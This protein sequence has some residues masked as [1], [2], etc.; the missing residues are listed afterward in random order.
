MRSSVATASAGCCAS[1]CAWPSARNNG[2][3]GPHSV[4]ARA[5]CARPV[6]SAVLRTPAARER[7]RLLA[8]LA[9]RQD[10]Q[11]ETQQ[12]HGLRTSP[13]ATAAAAA[14]PCRRRRSGRSSGSQI[15]LRTAEARAVERVDQIDAELEAA[16]AARGEALH[17]ADVLGVRTPARATSRT[18]G[19]VPGR[20]G[21]PCADKRLRRK[22][23]RV[24]VR[25]AAHD[26]EVRPVED[27]RVHALDD[28]G[29]EREAGVP[30]LLMRLSETL[31]VPPLR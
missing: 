15:G 23:R 10:R 21:T 19:A 17:Q 28:V 9:R 26:I 8:V 14:R 30:G 22:R 1:S 3:L 7:L 4:T 24:E 20:D 25:R 29:T 12:V 11:A 6:R 31:S 16:L 27:D 5:K 18:T 13:G 2:A